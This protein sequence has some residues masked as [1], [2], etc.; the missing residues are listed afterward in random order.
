MTG[1]DCLHYGWRTRLDVSAH[2]LGCAWRA[3]GR[4]STVIGNARQHVKATGH[5][6]ETVRRQYQI[7]G[8]PRYWERTS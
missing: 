1:H 3:S 4:Q 2:C 8:P 6:V 7:S 5:V